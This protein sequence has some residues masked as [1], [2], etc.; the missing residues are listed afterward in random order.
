MDMSQNSKPD[1]AKVNPLA[2]DGNT[3]ADAAIISFCYRCHR[4]IVSVNPPKVCPFC[5][6]RFCPS[7]TD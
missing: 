1:D 5:G 3:A 7:C 6:Y 2:A 4:D